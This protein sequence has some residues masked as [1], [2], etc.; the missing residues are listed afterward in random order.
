MVKF[1]RWLDEIWLRVIGSK[2]AR[3]NGH[4]VVELHVKRWGGRLAG[5]EEIISLK[6]N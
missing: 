3:S 6:Y 2:G 4:Y 1:G 5:P